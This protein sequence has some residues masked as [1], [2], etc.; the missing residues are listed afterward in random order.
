M[1][2][3][4]SQATDEA[5]WRLPA[6]L[7]PN[8][9]E[10]HLAPDLKAQ[11]FTGKVRIDCDVLESTSEVV[12]N[13]AELTI[14]EADVHVDGQK[15]AVTGTSVDEESE[16]ATIS[17]AENLVRGGSVSV[18]IEFT[19][20][21]NDQLRGFYRSV[22]SPPGASEGTLE[23]IATTHFES[24]DARRAFPC[25]DEPDLKAVFS[26]TVDVPEG[27]SCFSN[28]SLLKEEPL[29][30]GG[31]RLG[32]KDSIVMSSYLVC[33]VVGPLVQAPPID[34]DGTPVSVVH[35]P[36]KEGLADFALEAAAHSLRFYTDWFGIPYPG[37]KLDMIALPDFAMGAMENLGCITYRENALLVDPSR[38]SLAELNRVALVVAHE[39]A[40]MWFG[41]LVTMRWWDGI[42]LNEAFATFM[43]TL[44]VDAFR[45]EWDEWTSFGTKRET[46]TAI[47][48]L[49]STRPVE[50]PVG[51]PQEAE[52]M[53]DPLTYEKGGGMLRM[54][55]RYIG[56]EKFRDGIRLYLRRHS[57]GNT[58]SPDLWAALEEAS[59]EPVGTIMD[60]FLHRGG[61]PVVVVGEGGEE[62]G[63]VGLTQRP[64]MYSPAPPSDGRSAIGDS[65]TIPALVRTSGVGEPGQA[66]IEDTEFVVEAVG[67]GPVI[68]NAGGSGYFRVQYPRRH[69]FALADRISDLTTLERF[70]LV[71]DQWAAV[72]SGNGDLEDFLALAAAIRAERDPDVWGQ[73]T[74]PLSFMDRAVPESILGSLSAYARALVGP[75][76]E[77][78]GWESSPADS[79]RVRALRSQLIATLGTVGA[80]PG[81]RERCAQAH[82]EFSEGRRPIDPDL[83]PAIV[84][85]VAA[86]GGPDDY[87]TF[88][89]RYSNPVTPQEEIRYL[90]AL[91]G[92]RDPELGERTF[93]LARTKV[94][95]QNAPM[96]IAL[97]LANRSVGAATWERVTDH[98]DELIE[99]IPESLVTRMLE[100]AR[101]LCRDEK[102]SA[103]VA[104]FLA[105]H[106]VPSG[107]RTVAQTVERLWVN[108]AMA[109]RLSKTAAAVLA[110]A[111]ARLS[112]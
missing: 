20:I 38:A 90:H 68:A 61:I 12:L 4:T 9:Y 5:R 45:P 15:V 71:S 11:A 80:D 64:F 2:N 89:G 74:S 29:D 37:D 32:F 87:E 24:T 22:F 51:S 72:L 62:G 18:E 50:F 60:A 35:V 102:L 36:G 52:A 100:G 53:F 1:T 97:L 23:T 40:H 88:F 42:W 109:A 8:R 91:A 59:G 69:L 28:F 73:V 77:S 46:A 3:A 70:N 65:W 84:S 34:V 75:V 81:V 105:E 47:D 43:E 66:L 93:E 106:P 94:R 27:L 82:R 58:D 104:A 48:G 101:F 57:Y 98:W 55:E 16:R 25:F 78:L 49:H 112:R 99:R 17:L 86:S 14:D 95:V 10:I 19:G 107:Q 83:A 76:V 13:A 110:E 7:R 67:T 56:A 44:C 103:E 33:V 111:T 63:R 54:L 31:R 85:T 26:I 92:F 41:D 79:E 6:T 39:I 21:L 30:G 108:T 96:L